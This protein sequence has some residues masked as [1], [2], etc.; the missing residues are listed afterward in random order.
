MTIIEAYIEYLISGF[1]NY[2][3]HFKTTNGEIIGLYF[4]Y[5]C[6][7]FTVIIMPLYLVY[8]LS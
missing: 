2:K 8:T 5:V 6:F 1:L 3:Y 4:S 7:M